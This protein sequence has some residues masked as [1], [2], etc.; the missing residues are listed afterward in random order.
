[1]KT[2]A[3]ILAELGAPLV[4]DEI[5]IPRLKDGQVLV[6]VLYSG[7]CH[8]QLSEVMGLRG[9]D[10]YLPHCLGHE[11]TGVVVS[12]GSGVSKVKEGDRVLLS[13]I[14]GSG[15]DV[16]GTVYS[17]SGG[18]VNAGGI[19]TFGKYMVISENRVSPLPDGVDEKAAAL[20]GCAVPTGVG[21]VLNT[22][23]AKPC[24]SIAIFGA[25]G[26]GLCALAGA[27]ARG[28]S[29]IIVVDRLDNRLSLALKMGADIVINALEE[30]PVSAMEKAVRGGVDL[31]VECTG[32]PE[33]MELT[34][35]CVK[36]RGGKVG[37]VGNAEF[38]KTIAIDPR[39][40]NMGKQLRGTWGGDVNP[41]VDI[42]R[43]FE[44]L[45]LGSLDIE[46]LLGEEYS[47]SSINDALESLRKDGVGR[48]IIN[49]SL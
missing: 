12:L 3:A 42:P 28:C 43:Y 46:P 41:D 26:I 5:E 30:D 20:F 2:E 27:K 44:M 45:S 1:M 8:T 13:W 23:E 37:V 15:K 24:Q 6:E 11:G 32:A 49:M 33:V 18:K 19:T 47:L 40:L 48:P 7:V 38:G 39:K 17:W 29:P 9:E 35:R 22:L 25:G 36:A 34:L 14:K 10:Q 21:V 31:C 16:P 4:V